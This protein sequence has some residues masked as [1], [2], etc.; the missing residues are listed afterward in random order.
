MIIQFRNGEYVLT[1]NGLFCNMGIRKKSGGI[2]GGRFED[3]NIQ[4]LFCDIN[5]PLMVEGGNDKRE[6]TNVKR[7]I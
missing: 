5:T 1:S 6:T 3:I 2:T 7:Q 4:Y